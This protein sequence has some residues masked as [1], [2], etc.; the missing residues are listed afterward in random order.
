MKKTTTPSLRGITTAY[1]ALG[2]GGSLF[3]GHLYLQR[4]TK[5]EQPQTVAMPEPMTMPEPVPETM[6]AHKPEPPKHVAKAGGKPQSPPDPRIINLAESL[7]ERL[8]TIKTKPSKVHALQT[9]QHN[10][11]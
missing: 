6:P 7:G 4:P 8:K 3:L 9:T 5:V 11:Q 2:I 10:Q 1:V